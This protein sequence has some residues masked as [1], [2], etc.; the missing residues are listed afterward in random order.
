MLVLLLGPSGVGKSTIIKVLVQDYNWLPIVSWITREER[1]DELFKVS[2]SSKSYEMLASN[3]KLWSDVHQNEHRYGLLRDEINAALKDRSRFHI[4]DF[5]LS[6]RAAHFSDAKHLVV[7]LSTGSDAALKN[8]LISAGRP[9]R[10]QSALAVREELDNWYSESGVH[11]GAKRVFNDDDR[12][13]EVSAEIN[14]IAKIWTS[15]N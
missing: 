6:S 5:G 2:I 1:S 9:D 4:V 15:S 3:G 8:R 12:T 10:I 13:K 7:Y 14:K 11:E